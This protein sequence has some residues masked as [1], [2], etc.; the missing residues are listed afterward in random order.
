MKNELH[1]E[2]NY[3]SVEVGSSQIGYTQNLHQSPAANLKSQIINSFSLL[4][5]VPFFFFFI[6]ESVWTFLL[7]SPKLTPRI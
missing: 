2:M 7:S 4:V 3:K 6:A 1:E 5:T